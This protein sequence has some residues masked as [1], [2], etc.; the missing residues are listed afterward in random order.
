M[1]MAKEERIRLDRALYLIVLVV[2]VLQSCAVS[3]KAR[4]E[5]TRLIVQQA[6]TFV[7]TP[8]RYGGTTVLGMDCSG[9]LMRSFEVIDL[10]IPRTAK[11]QSKLGRAVSKSNL[12]PGDLV[13]FAKNKIGWKVSHAGLVTAVRDNA[14]Y[15]VHAS[16]SRGVIEDNLM[17]EYYRKRF[18]KA[19]RIKF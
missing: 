5:K 8:Y 14:V 17:S 6:R 16:S 2:V 4:Q 9:L 10:Y 19:R 13:F 11:E 3:K 7:G 15:F 1:G 18:V 12:R